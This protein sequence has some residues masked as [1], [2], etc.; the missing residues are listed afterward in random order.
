MGLEEDGEEIEMED[1]NKNEREKNLLLKYD[2][3]K[4]D[5]HFIEKQFTKI[6][7]KEKAT[8]EDLEDVEIKNGKL[9]ITDF[10]AL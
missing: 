10:E 8:L 7:S 1:E 5:F 2:D 3:E 9:V 6:K 4:Q